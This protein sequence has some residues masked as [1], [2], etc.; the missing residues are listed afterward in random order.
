MFITD[1]NDG[2][3]SDTEGHVNDVNILFHGGRGDKEDEK[4][5]SS[6]NLFLLFSCG[7]TRT[8]M[9]NLRCQKLGT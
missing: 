7:L 8:G 1:H 5:S 9:V 6:P 3:R 4:G 2:A